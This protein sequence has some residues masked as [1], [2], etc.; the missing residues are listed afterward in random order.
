MS[1]RAST[2]IALGASVIAVLAASGE[3]GAELGSTRTV[4][5]AAPPGTAA[6]LADLTVM[7]DTIQADGRRLLVQQG[8]RK[9]GTRAPIHYHGYGGHTC[10]LSGAITDFVEGKEPETISAGSC[11]YMPP[12]VAMTAAN[13]GKDDVRLI[14]TFVLPPDAPA[15]IVIEPGWPDLADPTG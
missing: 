13:T 1:R 8:I 3:A 9:P 12:D 10:V 7:L 2:A 14:D 4:N 6:P 15:I 5:G 11:Y